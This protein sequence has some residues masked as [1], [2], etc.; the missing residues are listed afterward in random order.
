MSHPERVALVYHFFAHYRAPILKEL[1][2]S[3]RFDFSLYGDTHDPGGEGIKS[4]EEIIEKPFFVKTPTLLLMKKFLFQWGLISLAL[5]KDIPQI[6][7]LGNP[8][9]ITTWVSAALARL[10]GKKV[11][12]WTHG[13][14]RQDQ[15]LKRWIRNIFFRLCNAMLLYGNR[16]KKI[17]LKNGFVSENLYVIYN[18]LNYNEQKTFR[19]NFSF[20]DIKHI[21]ND[22]FGPTHYPVVVCIGRLIKSR[23]IELLL[24]ASVLLRDKGHMIDVLII[25]D[26]PE[27]SR[28]EARA[29]KQLLSVKFHGA[30]YNEYVLAKHIMAANLVVMPGSVGLTAVHGLSYGIP[31]ISHNNPDQQMP[32]WEAIK[33]GLNGDFFEQDNSSDLALIIKKWTQSEFVPE[34]TRQKCFEV[35]DRYYNPRYQREIIEQALAGEPASCFQE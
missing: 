13:W 17:G 24:D 18:S 15:G 35:I 28:L 3:S 25:G 23:K 7:Y 27:L 2:K 4:W 6:I 26:G 5:R 22:L 20:E 33:P 10:A 14:T 30:C 16:A 9:Y 32:E 12:F 29:K 21:R 8:Y 31:V 11:F 19:E 1:L 34:S